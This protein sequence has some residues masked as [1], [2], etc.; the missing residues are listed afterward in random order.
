M[1]NPM[2]NSSRPKS[3][4]VLP[5]ILSLILSHSGVEALAGT[6]DRG[7]GDLT[8]M[9]REAIVELLEGQT[10]RR[11][12]LNYLDTIDLEKANADSRISEAVKA[13]LLQKDVLVQD[14][15]TSKYVVSETC[16]HFDGQAPASAGIGDL[17]GEICFNIKSLTESLKNQSIEV[18]MIDLA[19]LAFHEHVHHLQVPPSKNLSLS[20]MRKLEE[21]A[22]AF[23]S[24]VKLTA[25]LTQLP[26]LMWSLE[27]NKP[28]EG[29]LKRLNQQIITGI[30]TGNKVLIEEAL[31]EGGDLNFNPTRVGYH[32]SLLSFAVD[33]GDRD[34][35]KFLLDR[36]IEIKSGDVSHSLN[37]RTYDLQFFGPMF[38]ALQK[39]NKTSWALTLLPEAISLPNNGAVEL[40]IKNGADVN[41]DFEIFRA[42]EHHN[43]FAY[44][45]LLDAGADPKVTIDIDEEPE[46]GRDSSSGYTLLHWAARVNSI[47]IAKDLV[48]NFPWMKKMKNSSGS[49]P[50][51]FI[52]GVIGGPTYGRFSDDERK[53]IEK[54]M[55]LILKP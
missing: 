34:M 44:R 19:S 39:I 21:Q 40:L 41:A 14:I 5:L 8:R 16:S 13:V 48:R 28:S 36:G 4:F 52:G 45:A 32:K 12:M 1:R 49:T 26:V 55:R 3:P 24:Y 9:D 35:F 2:Q 51:Q 31:Q 46:V 33:M 27:G 37:W 11:A 50:Y 54:Q 22:Y 7:G 29:K 17:S 15:Q 10:L 42:I 20:Q 53:L 38:E 18:A 6:S 47:D 30:V 25:K 23:S 43:Y